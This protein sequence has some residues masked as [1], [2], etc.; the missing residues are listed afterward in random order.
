MIAGIGIGLLIGL[1]TGMVSLVLLKTANT[2]SLN[3][4]SSVIATTT[5][6]LSIPTFW[7]GGPW[8]TSTML[9]LVELES[10]LSPYI[11]SLSFTFTII[12]IYPIA[13]WILKLG[14]EL[15]KEIG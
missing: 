7:F 10:M 14:E 2:A 1:I 15:G 11:M 12:I 9:K 5:E 13:K 4:P 8:V 6:L 3:N